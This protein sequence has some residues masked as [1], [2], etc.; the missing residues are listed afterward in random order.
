MPVY[1]K[2]RIRKHLIYVNFISLYK[3]HIYNYGN[4][5]NMIQNL[6]LTPKIYPN[7]NQMFGYIFGCTALWIKCKNSGCIALFFSLLYLFLR[8]SR[9]Q[10]TKSKSAFVSGASVRVRPPED[11]LVLCSSFS[12]CYSSDPSSSLRYACGPAVGSLLR[13]EVAREIVN[14]E[15]SLLLVA[16]RRGYEAVI[17]ADGRLLSWERMDFQFSISLR[18]FSSRLL[19]FGMVLSSVR[20]WFSAV[21]RVGSH[22]S[23]GFWFFRSCRCRCGPVLLP[24]S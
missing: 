9:S 19:R 3:V 14:P 23:L 18:F 12:P 8:F 6:I 21:C 20:W 4:F 2:N 22:S 15:T 7:L 16:S 11:L 13:C 17:T 5:P 24:E 10:N 1:K